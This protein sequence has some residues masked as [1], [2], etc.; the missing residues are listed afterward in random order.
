M[1]AVEAIKLTVRFSPS[2]LLS[3][4]SEFATLAFVAA[5]DVEDIS[6]TPPSTAAKQVTYIAPAK[7][8]MPKLVELYLSH[9][10]Q[11]DIYNDGTLA[12]VLSVSDIQSLYFIPY[13]FAVIFDPYE[14]E[15]RLSISIETR[16]GRAIMENCVNEFSQDCER[17]GP[18]HQKFWRWHV[19]ECI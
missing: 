9:K 12:R 7:Y 6:D 8:A 18:E 19:L 1:Q 16:I 10:T 3:D 5:F 14:I 13:A 2:L 11:L 4:L 15:I 17:T